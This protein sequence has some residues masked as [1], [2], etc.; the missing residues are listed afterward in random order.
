MEEGEEGVDDGAWGGREG[1]R[2]GGKEQEMSN[3]PLAT[4]VGR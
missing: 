2:E 1:G 3:L 4:G